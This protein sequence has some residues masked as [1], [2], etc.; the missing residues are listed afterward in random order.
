LRADRPAYTISTYFSRPGNG[1]FIHYEQDRMISQREAARLQSFP[2]DF[3]FFGSD[4][5][6]NRQIGNAVPPLMAFAL[7]QAC[8]VPGD[9]VDLFCGA[10]GLSLGF[11][12][13]GWRTLVGTDIEKSALKTY[14]HNLGA[15]SVAG[16]IRTPQVKEELLATV[17]ERRTSIGPL[18]LLGGPPCQGFSTAGHR[19]SNADERNHLFEEY[20]RLLEAMQPDAFIF[21]NVMGLL[22]MD[23]GQ[24]LRDITKR[25]S[26]AGYEVRCYTLS[27]DNFGV[28]Q[29]RNRVVLL[30]ARSAGYWRAPDLASLPH[31]PTP[32]VAEAIGDLPELKPGEDGSARSYRGGAQGPYQELMRGQCLPEDLGR[33]ANAFAA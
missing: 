26:E 16:D 20:A 2:D 12:W 4:S 11:H 32:T 3:V 5:A 8:G 28:P 30:G 17:S 22:N 19:R 18:L 24:T 15:P 29:R 1:A 21:E 6:I 14:S 33:S 10:G 9:C 23:K 13:S 25:L 27:S 31:R 7:A